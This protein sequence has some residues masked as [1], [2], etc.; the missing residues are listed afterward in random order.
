M[1]EEIIK[2]AQKVAI[3]Q[4]HIVLLDYLP[5]VTAKEACDKAITQLDI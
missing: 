1:N 3:S 4:M 2:L 5:V